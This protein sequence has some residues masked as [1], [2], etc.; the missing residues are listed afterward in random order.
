MFRFR[1]NLENSIAVEIQNKLVEH[2]KTRFKLELSS[3]VELRDREDGEKINYYQT[4]GNS[5]WLET[6]TAAAN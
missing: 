6:R 2:V 4:I 1:L 5:P 3:L